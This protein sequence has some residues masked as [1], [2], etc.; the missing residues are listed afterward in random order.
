MILYS[1]G[2]NSIRYVMCGYLRP[3]LNL[4]SY[5]IFFIALV[6]GSFSCDELESKLTNFISS[7]DLTKY[8][9]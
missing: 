2:N 5:L 9:S 8:L 3:K 4:V 6:F 7:I 1:A